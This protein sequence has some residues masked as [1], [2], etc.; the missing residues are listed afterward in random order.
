MYMYGF[1]EITEA[2]NKAIAS[3]IRKSLEKARL[4][5]PGTAYFDD[6]LDRL[7]EA[8]GSDT[9]RYYV[10]TDEGGEVVG[11]IGYSA[12]EYRDDTAELQKLY[13]DDKA[14][15]KGIGY[16]MI[17]FIEDRMREAGFKF[18]YLETH[19]N[20]Q[21]AIHIYQKAG[22]EE[23]DRPGEIGHSAMTRFFIKRL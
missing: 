11:G 20:L 18:S 5:I 2:D 12:F 13:L 8:Y 10:L 16:S 17:S 3:L 9:G 23:M 1:R 7:S 22:Y 15:G 6:C 14:H 19:D 4:N 21:A